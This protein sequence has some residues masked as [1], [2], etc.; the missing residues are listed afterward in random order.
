MSFK[1]LHRAVAERIKK[2]KKKTFLEEEKKKRKMV[3]AKTE[4][5]GMI[6]VGQNWLY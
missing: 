1:S 6:K 3:L 4:E 5:R 2:G